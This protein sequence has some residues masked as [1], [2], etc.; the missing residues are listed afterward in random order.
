[1]ATLHLV[2]SRA[3]H[4]AC[5]DR[6]LK[7]DVVLLL[8]DGVYATDAPEHALVIASDAQARGV[9]AAYN[10][11]QLIDYDRMVELT[12]LHSPVVSWR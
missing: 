5:A 4:A 3:G 12:A 7:D 8:Q 1:M 9:T 11:A 2:F 6:C 10:S